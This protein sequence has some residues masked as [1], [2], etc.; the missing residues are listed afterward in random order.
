MNITTTRPNLPIMRLAEVRDGMTF[1]LVAENRDGGF[2]A[3]AFFGCV[4]DA[5]AHAMRASIDMDGS[6]Y[7]VYSMNSRA[8]ILTVW[9]IDSGKEG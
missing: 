2:H 5:L 6:T 4:D 3:K 1:V 7:H 8:V 9:P